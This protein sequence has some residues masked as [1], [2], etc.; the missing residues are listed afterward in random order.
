MLCDLKHY[1]SLQGTEG[2]PSGWLYGTNL[3][4]KKTGYVPAEFVEY[5]GTISSQGGGHP[6][7]ST[8]LPPIRETEK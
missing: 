1:W 4:T 2:N 3:Q 8:P 5:I 7:P 6:F